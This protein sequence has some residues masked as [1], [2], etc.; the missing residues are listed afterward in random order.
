MQLSAPHQA[1]SLPLLPEQVTFTSVHRTGLGEGSTWPGRSPW[2][3]RRGGSWRSVLRGAEN[4]GIGSSNPKGIGELLET[5]LGVPKFGEDRLIHSQM[6][7]RHRECPTATLGAPPFQE[8]TSCA[9]WDHIEAKGESSD[10]DGN[11]AGP[12]GTKQ[13]QP[14]ST[15]Y[16]PGSEAT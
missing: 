14:P 6:R 13:Y 7:G 8:G 4:A 11:P 15:S 3:R 2:C 12:P 1:R 16:G 10:Q 5:V 9:Q